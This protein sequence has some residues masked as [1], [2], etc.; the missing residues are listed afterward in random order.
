MH[1][2]CAGFYSGRFVPAMEAETIS[3]CTFGDTIMN[4]EFVS[5]PDMIINGS[6]NMQ[7]AS[8]DIFDMTIPYINSDLNGGNRTYI[9]SINEVFK[10]IGLPYTRFS[11]RR[12]KD[13]A[14]KD[15][16]AISIAFVD[17]FGRDVQLM[18]F[19]KITWHDDLKAIEVNISESFKE[20]MADPSLSRT[21]YR[22][23]DFLALKSKYAKQTFGIL[24]IR[25]TKSN[26]GK[27]L[28]KFKRE[29]NLN[30]NSY[31]DI[32][33]IKKT[34]RIFRIKESSYQG[35]Q[36]KELFRRVCEEISTN[37]DYDAEVDFNYFKDESIKNA[38][39]ELTHICW[40][41]TKKARDHRQDGTVIGEFTRD[42][43]AFGYST[44]DAGSI[45]AALIRNGETMDRFR[46]LHNQVSRQG[47]RIINPVGWL[48]RAIDDHYEVKT[49]TS[50]FSDFPQRQY[51]SDD[52]REMERK[53]RGG[54]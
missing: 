44:R 10:E 18:P 45:C 34:R 14:H 35:G 41:L 11:Y 40:R 6:S 36:I 31:L 24:M 50:L 46:A 39:T 48:I 26:S 20:I 19:D 4:K 42:I 13:L 12:Y 8:L 16:S 17:E 47:N 54:S 49:R 27:R 43:M 5:K 51:S 37:T 53:M 28:I 38:Q 29:G 15:S 21:K 3:R 32:W 33:P 2:R 9:I 1:C 7:A 25:F 22:L 52:Y 23:I 30:G